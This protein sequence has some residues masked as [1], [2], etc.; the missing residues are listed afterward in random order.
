MKFAKYLKEEAIPEWRKAYIDYKL[1]KKHLKDIEEAMVQI[2]A[3]GL[4]LA[5]KHVPARLLETAD[6]EGGAISSNRL[7]KTIQYDAQRPLP[8][9]Y[10]S[11]LVDPVATAVPSSN[12]SS[13]TPLLSRTR[14]HTRQDSLYGSSA[15]E[16]D[17]SGMGSYTV[18][19]STEDPV[20]LSRMPRVPVKTGSTGS[21]FSNPALSQS[22]NLFRS[23]SRRLT[24]IST[25]EV[26]LTTRIIQVD[27]N[28][29][30]NVL[31]QLLPEEREFFR[32]LDSQLE[33]IN[34]FY[35]EKEL[36]AVTKLKVIKQ[37]LYVANEWKRQYDETL[38]KAEAEHGWYVAEW[39]R[40]RNGLDSFIRSDAGV[41]E[42]VRVS[43]SK[44]SSQSPLGSSYTPSSATTLTPDPEQGL[45]CHNLH[46]LESPPDS[47]GRRTSDSRG[48]AYQEKLVLKDEESRRERLNHKVARTRIKAALY[49][50]YRSLEMIKNYKVLNHTGFAKILKKFDKT[51]G[52]KAS[53]SYTTSKLD[54]TYFMAS[55]TVEDLISETEDVF[56]DNFEQGHR[57]RGMA[58]LRIPDAKDK[59]HYWTAMR[60]GLYLGLAAPLLVQGL[61]SAF[62]EET[63]EEI[64][65]WDGLILV[66]AGLFLTILFSC[67]FGI[68]MYVWAKSRINY[69][70]IF[71]FDP[72]DN[73]DYHEYFELPVFFVLLLS[74]AVYFDFGSKLTAHVATAYWPLILI[75]ATSAILFCPLP[76]AY[77]TSRRWLISSIG[78]ILA[79][80]YYRVEFRDFFLADEM[81]SLSYS[82]EQFEFAICAYSQQWS[83][84]ARTCSTSQMWIT[85]FLTALPAWFRFL[86]CLRR[87]RDTLEWFPHLVNAGKYS[88]SLATIF[89]YFSYR[90]YGG[91]YLKVI[92]IS[93]ASLTSIYTFTWDVYMDWG[94]F[95]FGKHGGGANGH[96]FLRQELVYSEIWVYYMAIILDFIGRFSWVVRL[97]PMNVNVMVL[98]FTLA[99]LEVLRRWQW[100][101]FRLENEHLNNC[102]QFRAIKDIPLPFHIRVE[103]DEDEEG[104]EDEMEEDEEEVENLREY[105]RNERYDRQPQEE[106]GR[107]YAFTQ[108]PTSSP[109]EQPGHLRSSSS[110]SSFA[111]HINGDNAHGLSSLGRGHQTLHSTRGR[112][113][114]SEIWDRVPKKSFSHSQFYS[115]DM[116]GRGAGNNSEAPF[117]SFGIE[118]SSTFVESAMAEAGFKDTQLEALASETN[119]SNKFYDR[120]DFDTKIIDTE[121]RM[122]RIKS[123]SKTAGQSLHRLQSMSVDSG[124]D[125]ALEE[126]LA[127]EDRRGR[128]QAMP[129]RKK[130]LGAKMK[131]SIL[132]SSKQKG[133]TDEDDTE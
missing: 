79:S 67:L 99:L 127:N 104:E 39:S 32:F 64:P 53:K 46:G 106:N 87:Y 63:S 103:D 70:F 115:A 9:S 24:M 37:Q 128:S 55:S 21:L 49:E 2:E 43:T 78:R 61:M 23:I 44:K 1:G 117:Q 10:R 72:R 29:F 116:G 11:L 7:P 132:R 14:G 73:L 65:Y 48:M 6:F 90:H 3:Q 52:W 20:L 80:G 18:Y 123:R 60:I 122:W 121:S 31:G 111:E 68:N 91:N 93:I 8:S 86:Q 125:I 77:F 36:E 126:R 71:E 25:P 81:N 45:L 118:R 100:N 54:S 26:P 76:I 59:T 51:A 96:P 133:E 105:E 120:R 124:R 130:T 97:I 109:P 89:V 129:R 5:N 22:S 85:P 98:S 95:R 33:M 131:S 35:Q 15:V 74:L 113:R 12:P 75:V 28:S 94:L 84:L 102:G 114:Q 88:A 27:N 108:L 69:K 40:V 34:E 16:D 42:D 112:R 66:Y 82:I 92:Y 57:R 13:T 30:D 107:N 62:S 41:T 56:I 83:D 19:D 58:K 110:H 4:S 17:R 38:A 101:F 119:N 47:N 50:F